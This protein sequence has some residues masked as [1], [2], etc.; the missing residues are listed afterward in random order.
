MRISELKQQVLTAGYHS[1]QLNSIVREVVEKDNLE[2]I[3]FEQSCELIAQLEY[4]RDFADKCKK[5]NC[6]QG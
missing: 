4:Y 5:L 3:T 6:K 1:A 2:N